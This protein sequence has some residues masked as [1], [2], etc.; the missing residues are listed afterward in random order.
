MNVI[1]IPISDD[2]TLIALL[3]SVLTEE[4]LSRKNSDLYPT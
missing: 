2:F 3:F 1:N 4:D